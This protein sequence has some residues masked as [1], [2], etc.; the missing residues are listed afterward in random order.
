MIVIDCENYDPYLSDLGDGSIRKDGWILMVGTFDGHDYRWFEPEDSKLHELLATNEPKCFHNS[1]YDLSWLVCGYN[2]KVNGV[3]HDTMTREALINEY[4]DLGL[5]SCCKR[6]GLKGKIADE[7]IEAWFSNYKKLISVRGSV[8]DNADLLWHLPDGKQKMIEYNKQDCIATYELFMAQEPL[9]KDLQEAYDLECRLQPVII[10]M[11]RNGIRIDPVAFERFTVETEEKYKEQLT[12]LSRVYGIDNEILASPKKMTT[13]M[14]ELGITSPIITPT[15]AQSWSADALA[16]ID[17]DVI[18]L[19]KDA[20]RNKALLEKYLHGSLERSRVGD[21]VHCTFSPNKRVTGGTITGRFSCIKKG[22]MISCVNGNKK[23]E[24]VHIGDLVYTYDDNCKLTIK[25]VTNAQMTGHKQCIRVIWQGQGNHE[26]GDVYCT[27]E[28]LFKLRSGEWKRADE[29][30]YGDSILHVHRMFDTTSGRI[31]ITGSNYFEA[32]EEVLI[33]TEILGGT[34]EQHA[35][36]INGIKDD[37]RIENIQILSNE[38]HG[39]LHNKGRIPWNTGLDMKEAGYVSATLGTTWNNYDFTIDDLKEILHEVDGHIKQLAE[40]HILPPETFYRYAKQL[41][42]DYNRYI[43]DTWGFNKMWYPT[44]EEWQEAY[45]PHHVLSRAC[46]TL[47]IGY[48]K[49]KKCQEMYSLNHMILCVEM[50]NE[51]NDVYDLEVADTHCFIA[52]ELAVHNSAHPNLQNIPARD[53]K[54]GKEMRSLF[55]ADEEMMIAASD[56]SQIEYLLLAHYAVGPQAEWFRS[57]AISGV[58][59]HTLAMEATGITRRDQ[60]K[61][62][63]YGIIYGMGAQTMYLKNRKSFGTLE[64]T[65]SVLQQYHARLP[66]IKDT[67]NWIQDKVKQEGYIASFSGRQHHKPPADNSNGRW[68]VPY[69][70]C[71]NYEIQGCAADILKKGLVDAWEAGVFNTLHLHLTVHDENV[72]SVPYNAEGTEALKEMEQCMVNSYKDKLLV[73]MKV[74]TEVG[75]S[76]GAWRSDIWQEMCAGQFNRDLITEERRLSD[77]SFSSMYTYR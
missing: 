49:A 64:N 66:V 11:K 38:E 9:M 43:K 41:G 40:R 34:A 73:P 8:W 4:N 24:D 26:I 39:S 72:C 71:T 29:L 21:R 31:R 35:H 60:V 15:G 27:P 68:S 58:D 67:M 48:F 28:H 32:K 18:D 44:A 36:H 50:V 2:I 23:I 55:V 10:E 20:K 52:N 69:Y 76:W 57:Q 46:E 61:T 53:E 33:K 17:H 3:L 1:V 25:P 13:K 47:G 19:I 75:H 6:Y 63:N 5:D 70:K 62:M 65:R 74:V 37:N 54:H 77:G 22:T 14:N 59:F 56:Y 42:F 12:Q 7:T 51:W 16:L 30:K 45:E